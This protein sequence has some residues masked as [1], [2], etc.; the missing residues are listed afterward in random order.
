MLIVVDVWI[1]LDDVREDVRRLLTRCVTS[2]KK[3]YHCF[4]LE[5]SGC[6]NK[7]FFSLLDN[8]RAN[9]YFCKFI[10]VT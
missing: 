4:G 7:C 5:K 1:V 3:N 10:Y 2:T 9:Q 6:Y 8:V